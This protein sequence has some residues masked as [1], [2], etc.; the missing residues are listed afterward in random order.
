MS[1]LATNA[2]ERVASVDFTEHD[3][4]VGLMDGRRISVPLEWY[5]RLAHA[6][7]AQLRIWE[8]SAGGYGI[9]WPEIDEDLSTEGLLRGAPAPAR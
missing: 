2:D 1:S 8:N 9:H 5:P 4:V 7:P 6:T 3:L